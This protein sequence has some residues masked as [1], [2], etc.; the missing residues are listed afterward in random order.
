ML[1]ILVLL[2]VLLPYF[3][4]VF[5]AEILFLARSVTFSRTRELMQK[6]LL[7]KSCAIERIEKPPVVQEVNLDI[8]GLTK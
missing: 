2:V 5:G 1:F 4:F 8:L 3:I 6:T 7:K